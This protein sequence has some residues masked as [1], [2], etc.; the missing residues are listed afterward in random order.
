MKAK[1]KKNIICNSVYP[2]QLYIISSLGDLKKKI[3]PDRLWS[4]ALYIVPELFTYYHV[5]LQDRRYPFKNCYKL[6][7]LTDM[8]KCGC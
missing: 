7:F 3:D 2:P 5:R 8:I 4:R 6:I 1:K